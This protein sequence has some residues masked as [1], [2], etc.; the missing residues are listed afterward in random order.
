[1]AVE[2]PKSF[3]TNCGS[4]RS[5]GKHGARVPEMLEAKIGEDAFRSLIPESTT[6]DHYTVRVRTPLL[7]P[8]RVLYAETSS[9]HQ[10]GNQLR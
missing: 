6:N 3:L 8:L 9:N 2:C 1:M 10:Q 7:T 4:C 5:K